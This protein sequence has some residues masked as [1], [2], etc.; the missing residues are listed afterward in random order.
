MLAY[1]TD[2]PAMRAL[3]LARDPNLDPRLRVEIYLGLAPFVHPR[4]IHA[5]SENN[6][7]VTINDKSVIGELSGLVRAVRKR[8]ETVTIEHQPTAAE[9]DD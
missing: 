1:T 8:R 3:E 6:T 7:T 2:D 9:G 4:L 5:T